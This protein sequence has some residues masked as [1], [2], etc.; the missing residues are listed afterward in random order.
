MPTERIGDTV[1]K[2]YSDDLRWQWGREVAFLRR[3]QNYANFPQILSVGDHS[4]T[5][6]YAGE[7]LIRARGFSMD[8]VCSQLRYIIATLAIKGIHHRDITEH[9]VLLHNGF[10]VLIDFGWSRW[11]WEPD[12]PVPLPEVMHGM[13]R[14]DQQ[15]ATDLIKQIETAWK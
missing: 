2:T 4:I 11:N 10:V 3:L 13:Y 1:V 5:M 8:E 7:P 9:N 12:A 15:Q 6:R 14:S